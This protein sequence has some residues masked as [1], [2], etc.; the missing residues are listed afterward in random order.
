MTATTLQAR[1]SITILQ[2]YLF[3][4]WK[5]FNIYNLTA[6]NHSNV[7][8]KAFRIFLRNFIKVL[9]FKL[10]Y[11][12]T[13]LLGHNSCESEIHRGIQSNHKHEC[14][15][16]H[17][18]KNFATA[19]ILGFFLKCAQF[20]YGKTGKHCGSMLAQWIRLETCFLVLLIFYWNWRV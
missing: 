3:W 8:Q 18:R 15:L 2:S 20:L 1:H 6:A 14:S 19:C 12:N 9:V 5:N 7:V 13:H 10:K 11:Q 4:Q 17:A 16:A